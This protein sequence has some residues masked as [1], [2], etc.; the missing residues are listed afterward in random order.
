MKTMKE[1]A[2]EFGEKNWKKGVVSNVTSYS[3]VFTEHQ[4]LRKPDKQPKSTV[5]ML[6]YFWEKGSV[7]Q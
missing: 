2:K 1:Y 3:F 4:D 7:A 6:S 5:Y